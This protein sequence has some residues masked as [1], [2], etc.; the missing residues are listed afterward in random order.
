LLFGGFLNMDIP[1]PNYLLVWD[2]AD[3]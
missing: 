2:S 1:F 3:S